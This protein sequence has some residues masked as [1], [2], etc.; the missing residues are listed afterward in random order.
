M[1][2]WPVHLKGWMGPLSTYHMDVPGARFLIVTVIVGWLVPSAMYV[3][4]GV[5][6]PVHASKRREGMVVALLVVGYK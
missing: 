5:V 6:E 4:F 1:S 3:K 2:V